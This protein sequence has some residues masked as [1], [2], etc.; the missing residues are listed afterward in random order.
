MTFEAVVA[1]QFYTGLLGMASSKMESPIDYT[2]L[3]VGGTNLAGVMQITEEMEPMPSAWMVYFDID[4]VDAAQIRLYHW[5]VQ[6]SSHLQTYRTS[7]G[8]VD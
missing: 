4:D 3:N 5:A 1:T 8:S 7:V 6:Y 2:M